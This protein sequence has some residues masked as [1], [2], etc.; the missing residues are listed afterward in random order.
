MM[1]LVDDD[2]VNR[3]LEGILALQ[4]HQGPPMIVDYKDIRIKVLTENF[5]QARRF[6]QW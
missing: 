2:P 1:E 5:G 3:C 4:I 6:V